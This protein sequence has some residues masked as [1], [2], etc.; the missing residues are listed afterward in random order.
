[1][2]V[3]GVVPHHHSA[4]P[5]Q[6]RHPNHPHSVIR[7]SP[8]AHSVLCATAANLPRACA[9]SST[10]SPH[11]QHNTTTTTTT[12]TAHSH[13]AQLALA[14]GQV[15]TGRPT[16]LAQLPGQVQCAPPLPRSL[17]PHPRTQSART[18]YVGGE[19]GGG[20]KNTAIAPPNYQLSFSQFR[21][22]HKHTPSNTHTHTMPPTL[23]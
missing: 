20:G 19:E 3:V 21:H 5:Q 17:P 9:R 23:D 18:M 7:Q 11:P 6:W 1:M 10:L 16:A 2:V 8:P 13:T 12:T 14:D 4:P 15:G 22:T